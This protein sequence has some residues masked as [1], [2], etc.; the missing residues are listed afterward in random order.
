MRII[1]I[2]CAAALTLALCCQSVSGTET[3]EPEAQISAAAYVVADGKTGRILRSVNGDQQRLIASTTKLMTAYTA[4]NCGVPLD[5]VTEVSHQAATTEGSAMYLGVGET[6][7]LRDLLWGM[8]LV[9]GND[10]A[11]ALAEGC[12]GNRETFVAWMNEN[13]AALG[14]EN[15]HFE[16]PT[17]LDGESHYST[18]EDLAKLAVAVSRDS[19]LAEIVSTKA[20]TVAGR[21]LT[22]HNRLL[23]LYPDCT[24]MKT[25]YTQAAGR[26]LVS[27]A[28]W[29][30]VALICVTLND[31]D[32]WNDH[33]ALYDQYFAAYANRTVCQAG[34]IIGTCRAAN[35]LEPVTV[36][37]Q[38]TVE[39]LVG[40][41][42]TVQRS[43]ELE[44]RYEA[45]EE[46]TVL[47]TVR[48]FIDGYQVGESAL[49]AALD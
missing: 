2:F 30:G 28:E 21:S 22:N 48:Y 18:A 36:V 29:D 38:D 27:S 19:L 44:N 17:G 14:M 45:V 47:G 31:P 39:V 9:S 32:D 34:E 12:A 33:M 11:N 42:E 15:T 3:A 35:R 43:V 26:T 10:A 41:E 23:S 40:P 25:G 8:L 49:V 37:A 16:N 13:A 46:G 6:I 5:T 1:R 20:A 4:V 24:G 7:T